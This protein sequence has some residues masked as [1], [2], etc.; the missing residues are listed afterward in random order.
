MLFLVSIVGCNNKKRSGEVA[1]YTYQEKET[2][3]KGSN[4]KIQGDW[5]KEGVECYGLLVAVDKKG[6]QIHGKPIKAQVVQISDSQIKMKALETVSLAEV[7]GCTKMGLQKGDTWDET[8]GD[9]FQTKE[10]AI[11]FLKEKKLF[12]EK[13]EVTPAHK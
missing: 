1:G 13:L 2:T 12:R 3:P 9:L 4:L 6:T 10:E 5:L 8:D 11:A 7:K